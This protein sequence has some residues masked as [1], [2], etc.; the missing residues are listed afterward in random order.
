MIQIR[1]ESDSVSEAYFCEARRDRKSKRRTRKHQKD[2]K[3]SKEEVKRGC[4]SE[5]ETSGLCLFAG[6]IHGFVL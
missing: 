1:F 4:R 5:H 2:R 6:F 3:T